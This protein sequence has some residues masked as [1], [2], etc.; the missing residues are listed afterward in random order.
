MSVTIDSNLLTFKEKISPV[1]GTV[2]ET[3]TSLQSKLDDINTATSSTITSVSSCYNG[4]GLSK[5]TEAFKSTE[6]AVEGI[7][8]SIAEGPSK[9]FSLSSALL[10]E[11]KTLED[12]KKEIELLEQEIS[13]LSSSNND[14][15]ADR[16]NNR[17]ADSKRAELSTK[18]RDFNSKHEEA[19]SK[20]T[21]IKSINP[22]LDI[23]PK[24]SEPVDLSSAIPLSELKGLA[25][26]S[27]TKHTYKASN[28][29]TFDYW[30]YVPKGADSIEGLPVHM[31]FT[32]SGEAHTGKCNNNS[33]PM[34]IANGDVNP[35]GIVIT[36]EAHNNNDYLN[37]DYMDAYKELTDNVV[38]TYKA[39]S[40]K[41]SASGHSLGGIA[42][43]LMGARYPDYFSVIAPVCGYFNHF[44]CATGSVE[45][46]VSNLSNVNIVSVVGTSDNYS[47]SSMERLYKKMGSSGNMTMCPVKGASHSTT[48]HTYKEPVTINGKKYNNLM[49]YIFEQTKA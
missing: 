4:E 31:Y 29:K 3:I 18:E 21:E 20:L 35:N 42:T 49:E 2:T 19:K 40:N 41:I 11:I 33:L 25:R 5:I 15:M 24:S 30:I 7:K 36:F 22:T 23:T 1:I 47:Y 45:Q 13:T 16:I 17:K 9:V 44:E 46:S 38:T 39:D 14:N 32:G 28:G 6:A 27:Y 43:L 8:G 34:Y 12:L 26:G 48:Y 37:S 10:G